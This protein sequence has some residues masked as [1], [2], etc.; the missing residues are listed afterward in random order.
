GE[1]Y[2]CFRQYTRTVPGGCIGDGFSLVAAQIPVST[3]HSC[4]YRGRSACRSERQRM[5]GPSAARYH[6]TFSGGKLAKLPQRT[7]NNV[8]GG[9]SVTCGYAGPAPAKKAHQNIQYRH[10]SDAYIPGG[11]EPRLFGRALSVGC[12]GRL[13]LWTG[14]GFLMLDVI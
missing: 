1:R 13:G 9:L 7:H 4:C 5:A 11:T 2:F 3:A 6:S 8:G 10:C 14:L 12:T